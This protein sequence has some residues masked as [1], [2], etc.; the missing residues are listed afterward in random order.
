[1]QSIKNHKKIINI[2]ITNIQYYV[3]SYLRIHLGFENQP[4]RV[5][6]VELKLLE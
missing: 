6:E 1:M 2:F 4:S 5:N 3:E